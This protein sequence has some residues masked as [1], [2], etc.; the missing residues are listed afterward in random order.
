MIQWLI[1]GLAVAILVL[2]FI[3]QLFYAKKS[4]IKGRHILI[5]G[6]SSGIG[7]SA[8]EYALS[9]GAV[10]TIAARDVFKLARAAAGISTKYPSYGQRL[11]TQ[12]LNVATGYEAIKQGISE[13]ESKA[14]P[15]YMLINCAGTAICGKLEDMSEK[16][17]K[18]LTD[19]NF[20]GSLWATK[21]VLPS[22]KERGEGS[23]VL[24]STQAALLGLF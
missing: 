23:I 4:N 21:I 20:L 16:D 6:G 9:L 3:S 24:V 13:A 5:I 15:I 7:L 1:V 14:G 22:M 2:I 19:L 11:F 8:A 17:V 18:W 10:V 12:S